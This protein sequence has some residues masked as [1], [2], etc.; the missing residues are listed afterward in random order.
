MVFFRLNPIK[1]GNKAMKKYLFVFI[2]LILTLL[3][4]Q[5][6]YPKAKTKSAFDFNVLDFGTHKTDVTLQK[7]IDH[8]QKKWRWNCLCSSRILLD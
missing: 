6:S 1:G 3:F 5:Q 4:V 2:S 7:A 8:A